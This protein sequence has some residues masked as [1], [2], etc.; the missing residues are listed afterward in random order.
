MVSCARK[1]MPIFAEKKSRIQRTIPV[2]DSWLPGAD[3]TESQWIHDDS[4]GKSNTTNFF[5]GLCI[6]YA[7]I[8]SIIYIYILGIIVYKSLN[9]P[10]MVKLAQ[11][12]KL[13]TPNPQIDVIFRKSTLQ[14]NAHVGIWLCRFT[15][16]SLCSRSRVGP[17]VKLNQAGVLKCPMTWVYWTSPKIVAI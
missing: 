16:E 11:I 10:Q 17:K 15:P 14:D 9:I 3:G 2:I 4:C 7:N 8:V 5:L 6:Y 13:S 12:G 1:T